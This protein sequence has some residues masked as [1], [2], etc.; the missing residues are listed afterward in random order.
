MTDKCLYK[1]KLI[2]LLLLIIIFK[3]LKIDISLILQACRIFSN[4]AHKRV[5]KKIKM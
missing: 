2:K 1:T 3:K 4:Y 5:L